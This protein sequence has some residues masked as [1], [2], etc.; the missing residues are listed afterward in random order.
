[1]STQARSDAGSK[2]AAP[3]GNGAGSDPAGLA[4]TQELADERR[5][6]HRPQRR[7]SIRVLSGRPRRPPAALARRSG[8]TVVDYF[9]PR[10]P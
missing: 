5:Q 6:L 8:R 2:P 9:L 3:P 4:F 10:R 1:M 7:P